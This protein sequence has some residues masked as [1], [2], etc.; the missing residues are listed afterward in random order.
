MDNINITSESNNLLLMLLNVM[1][2][3]ITILGVVLGGY[4]LF[5]GVPLVGFM[6][7]FLGIVI[8]IIIKAFGEAV[9]LLD[10]INSNICTMN[11]YLE[12]NNQNQLKMQG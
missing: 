6:L 3:I 10:E 7:V 5:C 2:V 1:A 9:R 4:F 11:R 12:E 8:G